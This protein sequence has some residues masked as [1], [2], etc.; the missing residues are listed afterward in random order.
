MK[1]NRLILLLAGLLSLSTS[2]MAANVGDVPVHRPLMEEYTGTWCGYCVRGLLGLQKL[3]ELYP[4]DY[5]CVSYHNGDPME[6]AYDFPSPIAGY[7]SAWVDRGME[8][9]P[10]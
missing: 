9:D 7:P 2:A 5:V 3:A 8:V 4:D 1:T 10:Y 6:I